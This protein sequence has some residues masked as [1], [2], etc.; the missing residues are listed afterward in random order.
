VSP[1]GSI[2]PTAG[3]TIEAPEHHDFF[4]VWTV[5]PTI[6]CSTFL[7]RHLGHENFFASFFSN[8][9]SDSVWS[10]LWPH[11]EHSNEYIGMITSSWFQTPRRVRAAFGRGPAAAPSNP[12]DFPI[13]VVFFSP[14]DS[15]TFLHAL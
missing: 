11:F 4:E 3:F 5:Q 15:E 14:L 13:L 9:A 12:P 7:L 8:S 10:N 2:R 6:S 1:N